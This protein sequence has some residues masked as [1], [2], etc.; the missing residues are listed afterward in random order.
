MTRAAVYVVFV[1]ALCLNVP[2]DARAEPIRITGGF[3]DFDRAHAESPATRSGELS[4]VGNR[5]F[6]ADVFVDST[7]TNVDL[8]TFPIE[9]GSTISTGVTIMGLG[10]LPGKGVTL[11]GKTYTDVSGLNSTDLLFIQL[12]GTIDIPTISAP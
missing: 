6:S 5:G 2:V 4:L 9:A 12:T 11:D 1:G 8:A 7:E 10:F 3:L